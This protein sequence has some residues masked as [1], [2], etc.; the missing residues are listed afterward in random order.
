MVAARYAVRGD[1]T[2]RLPA[3]IPAWMVRAPYAAWPWRCPDHGHLVA[4]TVLD[5]DGDG[6]RTRTVLPFDAVHDASADDGAVAYYG[7]S[8]RALKGKDGRKRP[9]RLR[10]EAT[11]RA[12]REREG[13]EQ[14]P[15]A[16]YEP[17]TAR[18]FDTVCVDCPTRLRIA[19][20]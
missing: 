5:W 6:D 11:A 14:A 1:F 13:G 2:D 7:P 10:L 3:A 9:D 16:D 12:E 15:Q 20:T 17:I 19:L 18:V 8:R 4:V